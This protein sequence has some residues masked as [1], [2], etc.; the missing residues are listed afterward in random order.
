MYQIRIKAND[1]IELLRVLASGS[2]KYLLLEGASSSLQNF[3]GGV[4]R[5]LILVKIL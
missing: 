1:G 5:E 4:R 2:Q 3:L